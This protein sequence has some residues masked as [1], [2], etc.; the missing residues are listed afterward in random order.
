M[1]GYEGGFLL[2]NSKANFEKLKIE[3]HGG[4]RIL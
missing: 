4:N 3:S 1:N 2:K